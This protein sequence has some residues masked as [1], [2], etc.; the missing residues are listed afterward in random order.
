MP[1]EQ[2]LNAKR[3]R[4]V[5]GLA[6]HGAERRKIAVDEAGIDMCPRRNSSDRHSAARNAT[7]V[8]G[9]SN[10]R[11]VQRIGESIERGLAA[12]G[13]GDE[14]GDHRVVVGRDLAARL[15][16]GCRRGYSAGQLQRQQSCRSKAENRSR[17]PRHRCALR[18][19]GHRSGLAPASA[20]NV[21]PAATRNCHSTRSSPVIASV[22][23]CSTCSRVFISMNQNAPAPQAPCAIGD[24]LDR[25]GARIADGAG[26]LDRGGAHLR[27]QFRS[28]AWRRRLLDDLLV[29][30]LQ[31][32]I[33][34]AEM[35][36][37][38]WRSANT[39]ISMWRGAETY[40]SSST[41]PGAERR[42]A[43]A[44]RR[45]QR[46]LE[47]GVALDPAQPTPAAAR[48]RLDQHR[49]ADLVGLLLEEFRH[50]GVRR[51]SRA[52]SARPPFASA[53]W[54]DP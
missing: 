42:L 33:A 47:I 29:P 40:F 52:R 22:T 5:I 19:R 30:A 4:G 24:E 51:D 26:G 17:G 39:W 16:A 44:D 9:P 49:I 34:L 48:R 10:Q 23:G 25:A 50:P 11:A 8:R 37:L 38:P 15:D 18:R 27:A 12:C 46:R 7:L 1:A 6:R 43:L 53:P 54:R 21:S 28:H 13:V 41:R 32:T 45:F 2:A 20:A 35:D 3:R 31:R 14:L 36:V